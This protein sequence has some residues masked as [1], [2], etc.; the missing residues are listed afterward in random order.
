MAS[1]DED[2]V[3][4]QEHEMAQ[5]L[6][7]YMNGEEIEFDALIRA[8]EIPLSV[9][10][11]L[12]RMQELLDNNIHV[13]EYRFENGTVIAAVQSYAVLIISMVFCL[14]HRTITILQQKSTMLS[15]TVPRRRENGLLLSAQKRGWFMFL[16]SLSLQV[17]HFALCET[18]LRTCKMSLL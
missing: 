16:Q 10:R 14:Q 3:R 15:I 6:I 17:I 11:M 9:Q 2:W 5:M 1:N 7:A 12:G 13:S 4:T 18:L 8:I